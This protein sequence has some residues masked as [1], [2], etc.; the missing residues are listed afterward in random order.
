MKEKRKY[1]KILPILLL[2]MLS[3]FFCWLFV[4]RYGI[5]GSKVDWIS[6]HS[7][8]PDYFRQQFYETGELLPEYAANIGGGQ[9]I[10]H[11][12]Y[13]GLYSPV[14]LLSYLLPFVKMGDY[15][16]AASMLSL[17]G[18]VMMIFY[19]FQ[20]RGFSV[21]ISFFTALMFLLSGP[22]I[23]HSYSQIMFVNYMPFLCMALLGVDCYFEKGRSGLYAVSVFLM[24]MTS[25]YFSIGGMFVLVLYG[26]YRYLQTKDTAV[27]VKM[28]LMEGFRFCLPMLSAVLMSGILLIPT[29]A[30][31]AGRNSAKGEGISL[32][33]LLIPNIE[34]GRLVYTPY[35][36]GLTTFV[37]T[38][39][40]TGLTSRKRYERV[41]VY[42]CVLVL[43]MPVVSWALNGG[44]YIRD[45]A[46]IP[47]LPLLCY[48]IADYFQRLEENR[49]SFVS[50]MLPYLLTIV[51]LYIGRI[52]SE[53]AEYK[54]LILL[55]AAVMA[56]CYLLCGKRCIISGLMALPVVFLLLFAS[57]FHQRADRI[58]SRE[59]YEKVTDPAVGQAVAETLAGESGFYRME[60]VGSEEENAADLNRV[61]DMGQYIS[62]M[63]SSSYNEE[64]Q[65]F[66]TNTFQVEEPFRN[67]L[68]QSVSK[69]P[70]FLKM[71]GVKYL[72]SDQNL[73]GYEIVNAIPQGHPVTHAPA[74][75][76]DV[77]RQCIPYR[78]KSAYP[79]GI[80]VT[81][82]PLGIDDWK[83]YENAEALPIAYATDHVISKEEYEKLEFPYN[84]M[85]FAYAAVAGEGEGQQVL[86]EMRRV[87]EPVDFVL[88]EQEQDAVQIKRKGAGYEICAE[89]KKTVRIEIP[90]AGSVEG[91][92]VGSMKRQGS[93][94]KEG[95]TAEKI[96]FLQ[97]QVKNKQPMHDMTI[98][99]EGQRNKLTSK[100]HTYYNENTTF[101][102]AVLLEKGQQSVELALGK[103]EYE[104][105]GFRCFLGNWGQ[106]AEREQIKG[107]CQS[108]FEP[109][110]E[111]TRSNMIAG[112][113]DVKNKGYFITSIPYD[114][115]F[116]VQVDSKEI[117]YEKV[118]T[119][120]LGFPIAKGRHSIEII[121]HAP[122]A[123]A[124]KYVSAAGLV[125]L[126]ALLFIEATRSRRAV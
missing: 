5:F 76:A 124:G 69:N 72:I 51:L 44:L 25:F 92:G 125:M 116:E 84:Q 21:K 16:M 119:A 63:Y 6:Q 10:Y 55:D 7:V 41:L 12:S 43:T 46:L 26:I 23:F 45:K 107:L 87:L 4:G 14:I 113:V 30:A 99:L 95:Q 24:I 33:S 56:A 22:M 117:S 85:A 53:Y 73:Q 11:F 64:Y 42:G 58:E 27:T 79:E 100:C 81:G 31:L 9:N 19:W 57:V 88:P 61:W 49:I 101:S 54:G 105:D 82:C 67:C 97:F 34:V 120:F 109:D 70:V 68:M 78:T 20:K 74:G 75:R 62:S 80:C 50:G 122:G 66:C 112:S 114:S 83:I 3:L 106:G 108:H 111:K 52:P 32:A 59:F 47:F 123:R 38:V 29:A 86:D 93:E 39:L 2:G 65:E 13:Y 126:F 102:Y 103:G 71:M 90:K 77:V 28:F 98:W 35:G 118:N 17:A 15:L 60:Q 8:L 37:I 1:R 18:T 94:S 104:L 40:I 48:L 121:Y 91:Q 110:K 36:I 115:H 89:K 96:L